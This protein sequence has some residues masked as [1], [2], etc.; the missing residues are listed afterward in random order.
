MSKLL[1]DATGIAIVNALF[2]ARIKCN[3]RI[4]TM[5]I[6]RVAAH[7]DGDVL[8]EPGWSTAIFDE[9]RETKTD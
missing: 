8:P 3:N 7:L 4:G 6:A 5:I 9:K 1:E 2:D